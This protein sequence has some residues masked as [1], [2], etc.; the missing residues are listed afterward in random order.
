MTSR[1]LQNDPRRLQNGVPKSSRI[2]LRHPVAPRGA[3]QTRYCKP[4]EGAPVSP[5]RQEHLGHLVARSP[6]RCKTSFKPFQLNLFSPTPS[7]KPPPPPDPRGR[8]TE[9]AD[10]HCRR[11]RRTE[12][13]PTG[14]TTELNYVTPWVLP[15][16]R[17]RLSSCL[18]LALLLKSVAKFV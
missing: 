4:P 5:P 11:P 8:R 6:T 17:M 2:P 7:Y 10:A 13:F 12:L 14:V 1:E 15:I 16:V 9:W 3:A 18:K